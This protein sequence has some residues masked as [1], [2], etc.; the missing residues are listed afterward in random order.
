MRIS[1]RKTG[2]EFFHPLIV[3]PIYLFHDGAALLF[4]CVVVAI[5]GHAKIFQEGAVLL[6]FVYGFGY[7][8]L[9]F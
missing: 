1:L 8:K 6:V 9:V 4:F 7:N 3:L 2:D 5:K